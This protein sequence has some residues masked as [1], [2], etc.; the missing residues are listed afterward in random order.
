MYRLSRV[1]PEGHRPISAGMSSRDGD[2]VACEV[3]EGET[4]L[5]DRF[6]QGEIEFVAEIGLDQFGQVILIPGEDTSYVLNVLDDK[7][8]LIGL[9]HGASSA[10]KPAWV[11]HVRYID[12]VRL[13][14]QVFPRTY[15][16]EDASQPGKIGIASA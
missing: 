9:C 13:F 14:V 6:S 5:I 8:L 2:T 15:S 1:L 7:P 16:P 10:S 12:D 3:L 4:V 11:A